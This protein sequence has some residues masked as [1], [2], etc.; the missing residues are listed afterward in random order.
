M[1]LSNWTLEQIWIEDSRPED[2]A[3]PL[4][5]ITAGV[6]MIIVSFGDVTGGLENS[7]FRRPL[8]E[9]LLTF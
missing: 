6:F 3:T 7:N 5:T 2:I 1:S 8:L 4:M 9:F